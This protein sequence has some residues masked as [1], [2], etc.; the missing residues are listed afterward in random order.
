MKIL[1]FL[2]QIAMDSWKPDC[3]QAGSS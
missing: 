2:V 1:H 3:R